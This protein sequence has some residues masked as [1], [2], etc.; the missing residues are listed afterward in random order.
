MT[1]NHIQ[2]QY[3][4]LGTYAELLIDFVAAVVDVETVLSAEE[5]R[6]LG[7]SRECKKRRHH[8]SHA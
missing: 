2:H 1:Y 8:Q 7:G 3:G 4:Q 6:F 5:D